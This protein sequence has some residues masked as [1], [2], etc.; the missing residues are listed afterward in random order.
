MIKWV[1][2]QTYEELL[3]GNWE[4]VQADIDEAK[5]LR[6][7][8]LPFIPDAA[9]RYRIEHDKDT[10]QNR[11]QHVEMFFRRDGIYFTVSKS[12][13]PKKNIYRFDTDR[14]A[15]QHVDQYSL[16]KAKMGL[17]EPHII[18][19]PT[20]RKVYEWIEYLTQ[21]YR[22]LEKIE[23]DNK[24]AI[25]TFTNRLKEIPD[26]MWY[27]N[28]NGGQIVR[29]GITY[30]FSISS[31]YYTEQIELNGSCRT[32]EDFLKLSNNDFDEDRK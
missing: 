30:R 32:L 14:S 9:L 17:K 4:R 27:K 11:L 18:Q 15:F 28:G 21:V 1:D 31:S 20:Q 23:A 7:T 3:I 2:Q 16:Q 29:H 8:F 24:Q 22:N 26:V 12:N 13:Y 25:E 10:L 5:T 6:E 19:V